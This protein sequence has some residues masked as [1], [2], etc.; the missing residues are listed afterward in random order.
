MSYRICYSKINHITEQSYKPGYVLRDHLS[1]TAVT[2]SLKRSTRKRDG[3]PHG[4][5]SD[6]AS[7]GVYMDPPCYQDGGSLLHCLFTLTL[8]GGISLL[9]FPGSHLRRTLSGILPFEARTFLTLRNCFLRPRSHAL[10]IVF[11]KIF[12]IVYKWM[13]NFLKPYIQLC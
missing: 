13:S 6:L 4:F 3:P 11:T 10:L 9:H 5:L 12:Y 8:S 2:C 7:D 1:R